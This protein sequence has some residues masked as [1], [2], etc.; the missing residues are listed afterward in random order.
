MKLLKP[1]S[2]FVVF[3]IFLG[4]SII[5]SC[6]KDTN[7]PENT[8]E[9]LF[10]FEKSSQTFG[11]FSTNKI[12]L[13]DLDGDG[14]IDAVFSNMGENNSQVRFNN[15]SGI[16]TDSGQRLTEW[17]HGVGIGDL[18]GDGDLD[19]IITCASYSHRSKIYLNDGNGTMY[20]SG[21]DIGDTQL[22]G[23]AVDLIDFEG[24]GDLDVYIVYYQTPHKIYLN[25]G[26]G[27]FS[28]SGFTLP[29]AYR[30]VWG[31][32]DVDGDIDI[33]I[34]EL[35]YGYRTLLNNGQGEF[36]QQWR[37][38]DS[39]VLYGGMILGDFDNDGD[40]DVVIANGDDTGSESTAVF[41]N[42][43][44]GVFSDSGQ[45]LSVSKWANFA[46]GDLNNDGFVDLFISNLGLP[47]EA[48]VNDGTGNFKYSGL[49]IGGNA[50]NSGC[51]LGD[52]DGDGD[53][54]VFIATF[55]DGPNEVWFNKN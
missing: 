42:D 7:G 33:F 23:N 19:C 17:G 18:D 12:G 54:D 45:E 44:T 14:D 35:G 16:F 4:I 50:M 5:Q 24:D 32:L 13:G 46:L 36:E 15:G 20:D 31:D 26:N 9:T 21:Q 3:L 55:I 22:S 10:N 34:K 25:D 6:K 1:G 39:D 49:R 28:D 53:L 37:Y 11:S 38:E 41:L 8:E 30:V 43:G 27:T 47:N 52:F 29:Y 40:N 48:W 51:S 2:R